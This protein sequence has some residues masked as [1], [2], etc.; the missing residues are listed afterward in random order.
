MG[1]QNSSFLTTSVKVP[2]FFDNSTYLR[3][4]YFDVVW[5]Y[6]PLRDL[7]NQFLIGSG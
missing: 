2:V 7:K 5:G 1:P 3:D 6:H 4:K